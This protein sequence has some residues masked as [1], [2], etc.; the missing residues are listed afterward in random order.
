M[1]RR[2]QL[3]IIAVS[4]LLLGLSAC[5]DADSPTDPDGEFQY[6][7]EGFVKARDSAKP[8]PNARVIIIDNT[9]QQPGAL[10]TQANGVTPEARWYSRPET[11]WVTIDL[12]NADGVL[13][14]RYD[15][16]NMGVTCREHPENHKAEICRFTA[17]LVVKGIGV[18]Q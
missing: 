6:F 13:Y 1:L 14:E 9:T 18:P 2:F 11:L 7:L 5:K 12:V 17:E 4:V 10:V 16:K 8:V 3:L 15:N